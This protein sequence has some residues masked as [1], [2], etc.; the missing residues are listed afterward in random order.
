M[1]AEARQR[2]EVG[3]FGRAAVAV[4]AFGQGVEALA[5]LDRVIRAAVLESTGVALRYLLLTPPDGVEK[6]TG[7]KLSRSATRDR[8]LDALRERG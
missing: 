5:A 2:F 6:T 8:Y 7:G 1:E 3:M 4:V